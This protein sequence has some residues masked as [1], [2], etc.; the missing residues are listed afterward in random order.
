MSTGSAAFETKGILHKIFPTESRGEKKFLTR[1]FIL[2][3][4]DEKSEYSQFVKMQVTGDRCDVLDRFEENQEVSVRF[5]L[6]GRE[7]QG[8][9]LTSIN[10]FFIEPVGNAPEKRQAEKPQIEKV[11][12]IAEKPKVVQTTIGSSPEKDGL[13]FLANPMHAARTNVDDNDDL[14]F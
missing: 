1:D 5:D 2:E 14:P 3:K 7:W 8:K 9:Y 10:C 11:V 6:R 4:K 13:P 12:V